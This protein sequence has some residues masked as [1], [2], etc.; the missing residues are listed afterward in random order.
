MKNL[1]A[2]NESNQQHGGEGAKKNRLI[3]SSSILI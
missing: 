2:L 1:S 3:F